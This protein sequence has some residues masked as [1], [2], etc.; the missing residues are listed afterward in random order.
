MKVRFTG[1]GLATILALRIW[2]EDFDENE[3]EV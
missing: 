1:R 3:G 2:Q